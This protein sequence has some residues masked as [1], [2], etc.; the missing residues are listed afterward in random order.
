MSYLEAGIWE[1]G[2]HVKS[3]VKWQTPTS[4]L[5]TAKIARIDL[6]WLG[7]KN[8]DTWEPALC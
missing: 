5:S 3:H 1:M 2:P 4:T 8:R 7:T 6:K